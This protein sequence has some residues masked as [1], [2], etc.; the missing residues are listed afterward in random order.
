MNND[1]EI[2]HL[3]GL[4]NRLDKDGS[5]NEFL[6]NASQ[7]SVEEMSKYGTLVYPS[8]SDGFEAVHKSCMLQL[9]FWLNKIDE[10]ASMMNYFANYCKRKYEGYETDR[11]SITNPVILKFI[12]DYEKYYGIKNTLPK[13]N[14]R[15]KKKYEEAYK[16]LK[17]E[18]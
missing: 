16:N 9:A 15:M 4:L 2:E 5:F 11:T 7:P 10:A 1:E 13:P 14:G 8:V 12:R 17:G 18:E 6:K 3:I